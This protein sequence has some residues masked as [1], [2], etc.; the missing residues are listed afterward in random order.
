[1][2]NRCTFIGNLTRDPEVKYLSTG[3]AIANFT[4]AVTSGFGDKKET[5]FI[6]ITTF[7]KLAETCGQYLSKGKKALAE[8]RL[9]KQEWEKDGQKK[10]KF[11]VVGDKV[12]FLS[13]SS[14]GSS[15]ENTNDPEVYD[16]EPF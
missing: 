6:D 15:S 7:G 4:L 8:G 16:S 11:V 13:P 2:Y 9:Q 10:S 14:T 5:L 12:V 1:M 3:T